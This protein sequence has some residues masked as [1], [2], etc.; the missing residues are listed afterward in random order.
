MAN[1][2]TQVNEFIGKYSP[3]IA[4]A[5]RASRRKLR[6]LFP[7]GRELVYDNY[8]ALAIGY[9]PGENAS[10]VLV[11]IAAYPRWVTLFFLKG[12]KLHDPHRM[13]SGSGNRVRNLRLN[14]PHDLDDPRIRALIAQAVEPFRSEFAE[15][16]PLRTVIKSVSAKQRPRRPA[17]GK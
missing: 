13:L 16:G 14:A 2:G 3:E 8:N 17:D 12:N 11:S 10:S 6:A 4:A 7:F 9:S 5:F 15:A 1:A